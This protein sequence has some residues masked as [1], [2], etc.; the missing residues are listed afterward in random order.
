MGR[1]AQ[2]LG[3]QPGAFLAGAFFLSKNT[4]PFFKER[5]A[6]NIDLRPPK[7]CP[8][9]NVI[10]SKLRFGNLIRGLETASGALVKRILR[11]I[12]RGISW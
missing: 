4:C 11:R 9:E 8:L 3:R 12:S 10:L 2:Q 7:N 5:V 6:K 1:G